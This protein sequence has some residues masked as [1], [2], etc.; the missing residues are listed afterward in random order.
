MKCINDERE[1][2]VEK[3]GTSTNTSESIR[4]MIIIIDRYACSQSAK[5]IR[6][7]YISA[8]GTSHYLRPLQQDAWNYL[9]GKWVSRWLDQYHEHLSCQIK[10]TH[11]SSRWPKKGSK[12][13]IRNTL[14]PIPA[15]NQ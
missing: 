14:K 5:E 7:L 15:R 12:H 3:G 10:P 9:W 13:D 4:A 1:A 8:S 6:I 2:K 11:P